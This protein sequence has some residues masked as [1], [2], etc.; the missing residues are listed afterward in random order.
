VERWARSRAVTVP[1]AAERGGLTDLE[2]MSEN[3]SRKRLCLQ[4]LPT[5]KA[6]EGVSSRTADEREVAH[7]LASMPG[8]DL[9]E[10]D[11]LLERDMLTMESATSSPSLHPAGIHCQEQLFNAASTIDK[12]G[13][14]SAEEEEGWELVEHSP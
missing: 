8:I 9:I 14:L 6:Q 2:Q 13:D 1:D 7:G 11:D 3:W 12:E 5:R 10:R 4:E